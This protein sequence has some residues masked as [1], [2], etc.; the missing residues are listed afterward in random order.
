MIF[1]QN[2]SKTPV[3]NILAGG[4]LGAAIAVSAALPAYAFNDAAECRSAV[5]ETTRALLK[6]N[7]ANSALDE[8]DAVLVTAAGKC[9]SGDLGGAEADLKKTRDMITAASL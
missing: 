1:P 5:A 4:L 6:A 7:V 9:D 2:M 8:I 3:R